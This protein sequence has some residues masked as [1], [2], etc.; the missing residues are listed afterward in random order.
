MAGAGTYGRISAPIRLQTGVNEQIVFAEGG[1]DLVAD[2]TGAVAIDAYWRGDLGVG[3]D[4]SRIDMAHRL[5]TALETAGANAYTVAISSAGVLSIT[6][7]GAY[8]L[9]MGAAGT[10]ASPIWFGF[11]AANIASA[12]GTNLVTGT[13]Q[14]SPCWY[15][16]SV[17]IQ[18]SEPRDEIATVLTESLNGRFRGQQWGTRTRREILFDALLGH[19]IFEAEEAL[20]KESF[21]RLWRDHLCNGTE[22]EWTRDLSTLPPLAAGWT[23]CR[24]VLADQGQRSRMPIS[25]TPNTSRRYDVGPL[26]LA[27]YEP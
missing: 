1:G 25:I 12:G 26:R 15:P 16:Q 11:A 10:T 18:D 8:T 13:R 19:K 9:K 4:G 27:L 23:A 5:K 20:S 3:D 7:D 17:Y 21:Q 6:A 24:Y 14:I 22:F 2:L